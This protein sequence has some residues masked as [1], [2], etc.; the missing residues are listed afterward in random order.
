MAAAAGAPGAAG[1]P[2]AP[3]GLDPAEAAARLRRDGPN[4]LP[5]PDRRRGLRIVLDVLREP[6][7]LLLAGASGL[8]LLLGD[9]QEAAVL[10]V[11]VC[12]VVGLTITQERKSEHALQALRDLGS[13]RAAWTPA[14]GALPD[15][16][17][18]FAFAWL[19][20]SLIHN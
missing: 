18:G 2:P 4:L 1:V 14:D 19:G 6:M 13:P 11:S 12:L 17:R 3:S 7:L 10:A 15:S 5:Q 20:L 8:Y 16:P 9:P